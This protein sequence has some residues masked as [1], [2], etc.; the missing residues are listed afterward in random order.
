MIRKQT[1][2]IYSDIDWHLLWGNARAGKAWKSKTSE[3]WSS[4][5]ATFSER[6]KKSAYIDLFLALVDVS[7][8]TTILDVG[9][10]PG[11]LAI[12][13]ARMTK[14]VTAIDYSDGMIQ[15]LINEA[16]R[17]K[18]LN[19]RAFKCSWEEDWGHS[20][21]GNHDIAIASRSLNIDNLEDGI[22]KLDR[23][24]TKKVIISDRIDPTPFDPDI[25]EALGR[26]FNSG[27]DY[28]YTVNTL[29]KL[30]IHPR[31][32]HIELPAETAFRNLQEAVDSYQ[33]MLKDL[34]EKEEDI[35]KNF[36]A[37]RARQQ[38][39][40]TLVIKRRLPSKWAVLSWSK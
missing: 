29:Y 2:S 7:A 39:D 4:K 16:K 28:I 38:R 19:I 18:I 27:P 3:H 9:C 35:L 5:A 30:G 26:P 6:V 11:T 40:G 15:E 31:I 36:I 25:F 34:T 21:V 10:G 22:K 8:E 14:S 1:V 24:A 12:P 33:W 37:S 17:E 20:S 13:L 32:D 23:H